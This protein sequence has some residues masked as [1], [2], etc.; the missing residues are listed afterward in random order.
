MLARFVLQFPGSKHISK[1][2]N[3]TH[4]LNDNEIRENYQRKISEKLATEQSNANEQW[5]TIRDVIKSSAEECCGA[6]HAP[7][8]SM[9]LTD[10]SI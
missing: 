3:D 10:L 1:H 4:K 8:R 9:D 2:R 7:I 6:P 5:D